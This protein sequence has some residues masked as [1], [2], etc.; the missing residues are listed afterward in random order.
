MYINTVPYEPVAIPQRCQS[1]P[2]TIPHVVGVGLPELVLVFVHMEEED[3]KVEEDHNEEGHDE[4][5]NQ[6][7]EN[8]GQVLQIAQ[9]VFQGS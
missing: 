3:G 6:R 1:F 7:G 5:D 2:S 4:N 8:P 9:I